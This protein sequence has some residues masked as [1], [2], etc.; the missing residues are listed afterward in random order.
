MVK[1]TTEIFIE[2]SMLIHGDTYDYTDSIYDVGKNPIDIG[3]KIHGIFTIGQAKNHYSNRYKQGCSDCTKIDMIKK[4]S[5]INT[6][7]KR[8]IINLS[9][10]QETARERGGKCIS[11]KYVSSRAEMEWKCCVEE[12]PSWIIP[13]H[14]IK[15]K[16]SWC[17]Q[18]GI[19]RRKNT[20]DD[21]HALAAKNGG[22]CLSTEYETCDDC[23]KWVC[24]HNH[25]VFPMR[26]NDVKNGHW[27]PGCV[28]KT[29]QKLRTYISIFFVT[30]L[31]TYMKWCKN[32]DTGHYLPFDIG[33]E[34]LKVFFEVD[35]KQHYERIAFFNKDVSLEDIQE[36]DRLKEKKAI[37]NVYS[38]VRIK[39]VNVRKDIYNDKTFDWKVQV[40][41][42]C[43]MLQI[44]KKPRVIHLYKYF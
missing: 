43:V 21:C 18:C 33:I 19:D 31:S 34:E 28:N 10:C 35:G 41:K 15:H 12:H 27:C 22:K 8:N 4:L 25:N 11:D 44:N 7:K 5:I 23:L 26:Y 38:V 13:Y 9:M 6:G 3:C 16:D 1:L 36:R 32:P 37:E 29:E 2:K 24:E 39:C 14:S 42:A 20:M 17:N 40:H 30:M